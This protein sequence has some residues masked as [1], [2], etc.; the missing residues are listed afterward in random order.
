M[1]E[2]KMTSSRRHHLKSLILQIALNWIEEEKKEKVAT[3]EAYMRD[4]C[5]APEMSGDQAALM[6]VCKKLQALIDKVD[7]ERYDA[8]AKVQKADKEIEDL[9]I[10]VVDLRGVKK[11]ALK[12]VRMSA[13]SMLQALLGSKHKVTMDLRSN[14]KQVKKEVK[15]ETTDTVGD[16]RKNIEDKADRKKMFE[17]S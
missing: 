4:N 10:K 17:T 2:K 1:S 9:K 16:W 7:E 8:E 6:E 12:K 5:P 13:D 15:E 3:K 14:L 11:P